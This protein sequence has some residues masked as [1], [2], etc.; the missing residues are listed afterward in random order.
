MLATV[1]IVISQYRLGV[2]PNSDTKLQKLKCDFS[3]FFLIL[4]LLLSF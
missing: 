2:Q 4:I 3:S 1:L